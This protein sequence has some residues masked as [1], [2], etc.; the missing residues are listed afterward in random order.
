MKDTGPSVVIHGVGR[1]FPRMSS[2]SVLTFNARMGNESPGMNRY[3]CESV[4]YC[5]SYK[6]DKASLKL[7]NA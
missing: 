4:L 7:G 3:E 1:Q 2:T 5:H 6:G